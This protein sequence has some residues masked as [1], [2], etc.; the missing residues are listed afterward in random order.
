MVTFVFRAVLVLLPDFMV[1]T[2]KRTT[3]ERTLE[4]ASHFC[5]V[6]K[7]RAF[8]PTAAAPSSSEVRV[9]EKC[10]PSRRHAVVVEPP[11][12]HL[13]ANVRHIRHVMRE[14]RQRQAVK[15]QAQPIP[16]AALW[17]SKQYDHVQS[18]VKQRLDEVRPKEW[19]ANERCISFVQ[20][21][22]RSNSR[23]QSAQGNYLRAHENTGPEF[24]RAQSAMGSRRSSVTSLRA[25]ND[26]AKPDYVKIN[27]RFVR[28][29]PQ[30][31][32]TMS[33]ALVEQ[34]REKKERDLQF[35]H[36]KQKGRVPD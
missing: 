28:T 31:R 23:P 9:T 30:V 16:V 11:K 18:K 27:S 24:L 4:R 22:Q 29:I 20:D 35:Y 19:H 7:A 13:N 8:S 10:Q 6:C 25:D 5:S 3:S 2:P 15:E 26:T 17:R 1:V 34:V 36:E 12:N 32:K 14:V 33:E 21:T